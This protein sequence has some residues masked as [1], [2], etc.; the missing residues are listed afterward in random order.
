MSGLRIIL[1]GPPGAGKGTV[2]SVVNTSDY[3]LGSPFSFF[4]LI[5]QFTYVAKFIV[6][7]VILRV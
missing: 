2:V 3:T 1:V 7:V 5:I 6:G 4:C